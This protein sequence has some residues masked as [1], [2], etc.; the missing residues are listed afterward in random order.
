MLLLHKGL[1]FSFSLEMKPWRLIRC[2]S[3]FPAL[4]VPSSHRWHLK[5]PSSYV[6]KILSLWVFNSLPC[7]DSKSHCLQ[8]KWCLNFMLQVDKISHIINRCGLEFKII[9][10]YLLIT[11]EPSRCPG[12]HIFN[13]LKFV[14]TLDYT[15][16]LV[17]LYNTGS[18]PVN[19]LPD[20][21]SFLL[22]HPDSLYMASA[23]AAEQNRTE[24]KCLD[25]RPL[26]LPAEQPGCPNC[27]RVR[28]RS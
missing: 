1:I 6:M 8:E 15:P 16:D 17:K 24:R 21:D 12:A 5:A 10:I 25:S 18:F 13:N 20:L 9:T 4:L 19:L 27:S 28:D 2:S 7:S 11:H 14:D 3:I 26:C 22:L 23:S